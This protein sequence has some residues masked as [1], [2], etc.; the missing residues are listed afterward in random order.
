MARKEWQRTQYCGELTESFAGQQ[1]TLDGWVQRTRN[2]GGVIFVWLRDRT[3]LVQ[4][5]FSPE[6]C[7]AE[8]FAVG[9]SLRS[10]YVVSI[11]GEVAL[12]AEKDVTDKLK[13]GKIEMI[14]KK[15]TLLNAAATPPIYIDDNADEN[16]LVRLKFPGRGSK[17]T[18]SPWRST[19]PHERSF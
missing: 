18:A 19:P 3:G 16:E 8:T 17:G 9:E 13:T 7:D 2:L 11:T 12:R 5:V 1:V 15:A 14:A 6:T 10:E 4:V